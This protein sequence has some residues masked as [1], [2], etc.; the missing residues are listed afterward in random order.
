M[1]TT[2]L[3]IF[4]FL[5]LLE[6]S[7]QEK[8]VAK[9]H[10]QFKHVNDTTQRDNYLRDEVVVYL[11]ETGSYYTS[12]SAHRMQEQ[13]QEQLGSS[14]FDGNLVIKSGGSPIRESYLIDIAKDKVSKVKKV[15][16]REFILQEKF[17]KMDWAIEEDT[18]VIGGYN[19][20]K[21]ITTFKGRNYE[22]WF[23]TDIPMAFGPWKLNGL[24]GLILA[25]KDD[26]G[27]V[28]FEYAGFDK[29]D[30]TK[31]VLIQPSSK[32][33]EST[34]EEIVKM[35]KAFE[36]NPAAFLSAQS[37]GSNVQV[38]KGNSSGIVASSF[39]GSSTPQ[40]QMS[41]S[42]QGNAGSVGNLDA[43][44]IKSMTVQ[45]DD[46]YKPSPVTNNPIELTK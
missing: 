33:I 6:V 5:F 31:V 19:C 44:K 36:A 30:D 43:S 32:A 20:Q 15:G 29:L 26:K 10:Y 37:S 7:A 1:K 2:V 25:A 17:P 18:K 9:I 16:S 45:K 12:N 27:E 46:G 24:P 13:M 40:G 39:Q 4:S 28:I 22:A 42:V 41:F 23:T 21:A 8:A 34:E 35:E 14:T 11:G 38:I 3:T